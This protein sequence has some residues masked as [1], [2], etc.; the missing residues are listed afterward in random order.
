[1]YATTNK[2][3]RIRS[4]II[5]IIVNSSGALLFLSVASTQQTRNDSLQFGLSNSDRIIITFYRPPSHMNFVEQFRILTGIMKMYEIMT[6]FLSVIKNSRND[7]VNTRYGAQKNI[8]ITIYYVYGSRH[9]ESV[10]AF[11][12]IL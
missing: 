10:S 3:M 1:M 8:S 4:S 5:I 12:L 7:I 2:L 9:H 6:I 11:L